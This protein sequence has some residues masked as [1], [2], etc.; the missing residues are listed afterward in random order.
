[1]TNV[2]SDVRM[3]EDREQEGEIRS[4]ECDTNITYTDRDNWKGPY[5]L[6][7][8]QL[9]IVTTVVFIG[10]CHNLNKN[11]SWAAFIQLP[12]SFILPGSSHSD[13][14]SL[15]PGSPD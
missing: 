11:A 4:C 13:T 5:M 14:I 3:R 8:A 15:L 9:A 2:N 12:I 10:H 1:M 6:S 7:A